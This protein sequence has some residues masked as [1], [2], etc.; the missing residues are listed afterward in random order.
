LFNDDLFFKYV[1]GWSKVNLGNM[2]TLWFYYARWYK[3][4]SW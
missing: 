1:V 3:I 4:K 2:G